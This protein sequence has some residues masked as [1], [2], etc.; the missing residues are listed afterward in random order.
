MT[1]EIIM[2]KE[3]KKN[4]QSAVLLMAKGKDGE[5]KEIVKTI[6]KSIKRRKKLPFFYFFFLVKVKSVSTKNQN[7][8]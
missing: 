7:K 8:H 2:E 3:L 4:N 6:K 1:K 5:S